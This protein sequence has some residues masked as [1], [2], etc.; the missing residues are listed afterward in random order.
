LLYKEEISAKERFFIFSKI[1][2][3][4]KT[5]ACARGI[6]TQRQQISQLLD[7]SE[8]SFFVS[9]VRMSAFSS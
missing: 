6:P 9:A 8:N 5:T 3:L 1:R 7:M 2:N 4:T